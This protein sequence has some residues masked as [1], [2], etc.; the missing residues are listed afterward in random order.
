MLTFC[1]WPMFVFIFCHV[2][3]DH[4]V[5]VYCTHTFNIRKRCEILLICEPIFTSRVYVYCTIH[6]SLA[7]SHTRSATIS[8]SSTLWIEKMFGMPFNRSNNI[9]NN[10]TIDCIWWEKASVCVC[11]GWKLR[12]RLQCRVFGMLLYPPPGPSLWFFD[13]GSSSTVPSLRHRA[14]SNNIQMLF[15]CYVRNMPTSV[16]PRSFALI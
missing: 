15:P 2:Y 14:A 1:S 8:T 12:I 16:A 7:D 5:C 13:F 9:S 11:V 10:I 3:F 6:I 4:C